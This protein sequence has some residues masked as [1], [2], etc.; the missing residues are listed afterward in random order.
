MLLIQRAISQY[1][2]GCLFIL[3]I[4]TL[5]PRQHCFSLLGVAHCTAFFVTFQYLTLFHIFATFQSV[6]QDKENEEA[7]GVPGPLESDSSQDLSYVRNSYTQT[8]T[9]RT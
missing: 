2:C 9:A 1:R 4:L 8:T 7:R 6:V 5:T 3:V